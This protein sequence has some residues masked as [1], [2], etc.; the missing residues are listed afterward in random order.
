MDCDGKLRKR[1]MPRSPLPS[2]TGAGEGEPLAALWKFQE[3][4]GPDA[5]TNDQELPLSAPSPGGEGRD[6]GKPVTKLIRARRQTM[7]EF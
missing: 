5:P 6:E 3:R 2:P 4:D 7:G 1:A